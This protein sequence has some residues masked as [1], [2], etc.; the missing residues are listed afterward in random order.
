M[1]AMTDSVP[2]VP[3]T[4]PAPPAGEDPLPVLPV[5]PDG[6]ASLLELEIMLEK[7]STAHNPLGDLFSVLDID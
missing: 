5:G 3:D 4:L 7:V 6:Y 2:A 1:L